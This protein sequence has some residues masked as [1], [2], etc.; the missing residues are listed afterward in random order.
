VLFCDNRVAT[1]VGNWN[2][3]RSGGFVKIYKLLFGAKC[4]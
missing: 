1:L 3:A 4:W 2:S